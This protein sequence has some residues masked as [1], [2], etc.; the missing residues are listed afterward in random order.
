MNTDP[1]RFYG[2]AQGLPIGAGMIVRDCVV[3]VPHQTEMR[4]E[5]GVGLGLILTHECDAD[6]QNE[7]FFNDLVLVCPI[8]PLDDFCASAEQDAGAG[9][10]GGILPNIAANIVYRAMYLPP[11]P[12]TVGI[13][14][15][16]EG[17]RNNLSRDT[18]KKAENATVWTFKSLI[19]HP[20]ESVARNFSVSP[21]RSSS[22]T[23]SIG[24]RGDT[25]KF[26]A[27]NSRSWQINSLAI[28]TVAFSAF[29]S[30]SLNH[31]SSTR[32]AWFH[33]ISQHA[34]CSL[35]A[36]GLRAFDFKL[37]N[38]LLREKSTSL[39]FAR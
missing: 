39:W 17:G 12:R 5:T 14:E 34:V 26:H 10:W 2:P 7:R 23:S 9:A 29:F 15:E 16:M 35:S 33:D 37:Q 6:Q 38:H 11:I 21:L 8:I 18:L 36:I 28:P 24:S 3:S 4:F 1:A 31:I 22:V 19:F 13:L 30:V 27:A 25:E 32:M 20:P